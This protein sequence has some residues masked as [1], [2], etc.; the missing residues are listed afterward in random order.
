MGVGAS[1]AVFTGK[2]EE[3]EDEVG[4]GDLGGCDF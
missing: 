1:L 2:E 3:E 4:N